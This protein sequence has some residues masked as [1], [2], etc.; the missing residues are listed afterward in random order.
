MDQNYIKNPFTFDRIEFEKD[1]VLWMEEDWLDWV[2]PKS[3]IFEGSRGSGKTSDLKSLSWE[4]V[5]GLS[6]KKIDG[7]KK[8]RDYIKKPKHIGVY[9]KV[10]LM[11]ISYWDKWGIDENLKGR[12]FSTFLEFIIIDLFMNAFNKLKSNKSTRWLFDE[13]NSEYKFIKAISENLFP[14]KENRPYFRDYTFLELKDH[15]STN[16]RIIKDIVNRNISNIDFINEFKIPLVSLGE[17]IRDLGKYIIE[18]F[19]NLRNFNFL[20]LLDDCHTLKPWQARILNT[21]IRTA[22][23]PFAYKISSLLH[24]YREFTTN[25][26]NY[27]L[28]P[29]DIQIIP[30]S[31][32]P[33]SPEF[34]KFAEGVCKTRMKKY[35]S[36]KMEDIFEKFSL[37]KAFGAK[38]DINKEIEKPFKRSENEEAINFYKLYKEKYPDKKIIDVWLI[39]RDIRKVNIETQDK[40]KIRKSDTEFFRKFRFVGAVDICKKYGFKMPY[41]RLDVIS[42]LSNGCVRDF[43]R[44]VYSIFQE[45]GLEIENF[46]D[47][48]NPLSISKQSEGIINAAKEKYEFILSRSGTLKNEIRRICDTLGKLFQELQIYP[49]LKTAPETASVKL[50]FTKLSEYLQ[51]LLK[52]AVTFGGI[53][54]KQLDPNKNEVLI[55]LNPTL[56]PKFGISYRSMTYY[57]QRISEDEFEKLLNL[58]GKKI[59]KKMLD[60]ILDERLRK[61]EILDIEKSPLFSK[62][63]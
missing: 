26:P 48:K 56:S 33:K 55:G 20:I 58:K 35:Y 30:T 31:R 29:H 14:Y 27:Q 34:K 7:C 12:Y 15:S 6:E 46:V 5:F 3:Q 53:E 38:I 10:A 23:Q 8:V 1:T 47:R 4:L 21:A 62:K 54:I 41:G 25:T 49:Y 59:S 11:N 24:F 60:K 13:L 42:Y 2:I 52:Q 37:E 9:F 57:P 63:R 18:H 19:K 28:T 32:D 61:K 36:E 17:R 44:I 39:E 16:F 40:L 43:L 22:E 45:S 51:E 50:N